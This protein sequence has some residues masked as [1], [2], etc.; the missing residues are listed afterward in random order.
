MVYTD[1]SKAFD[2]VD[3]Y[4][5]LNKLRVIGFDSCSV[6]L[7]GSYL[8]GREQFVFYNGY[9]SSNYTATSGVPQGSNLG[10]LL[11]NLFINDLPELINCKCLLFAD[12]LKIF[13][14][15]ESVQDCHF[16]QRQLNILED[17]CTDNKLDLNVS[18]CK[19]CTCL[20]YTS[21]AADD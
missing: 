10:P 8:N 14:Q 17:W 4:T 12:D 19:I 5:L 3:H 15:V 9:R 6:E 16:L 1:F 18:K 20:L 21:D 7:F 2:R 13:Y 11:F